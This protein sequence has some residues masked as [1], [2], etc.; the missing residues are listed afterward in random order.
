[1]VSLD[2]V[3]SACL[4]NDKK[5]ITEKQARVGACGGGSVVIGIQWIMLLTGFYNAPSLH[6]LGSI[7]STLNCLTVWGS[8]V[9]QTTDVFI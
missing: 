2:N 7:L 1:M 9:N 8:L 5:K 6:T 4:Q 3:H